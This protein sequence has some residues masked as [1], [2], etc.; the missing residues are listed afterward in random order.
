[1]GITK[2]YKVNELAKDFGMQTTQLIEILGK[3]FDTPKKSG[4]NLEDNELTLIFE[5]LT[6]HNQVKSLEV[7]YADTAEKP[8][9]AS[10]KPVSSGQTQPAA[11]ANTNP[12]K[13]QNKPAQQSQ[14]GQQKNNQQNQQQP[15]KPAAQQQTQVQQPVSRVPKTKV[16]DTRKATNVNLDIEV[17]DSLRD[18]VAFTRK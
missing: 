10:E 15:A 11:Q 4:Q 17:P 14:S 13:Q 6:Q 12:N 3:Y 1:M 7:I 2:K 16:V 18:E 8:D 9:A 5:Y